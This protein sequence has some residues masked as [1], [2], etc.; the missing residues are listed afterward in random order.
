MNPLSSRAHA[1]ELARLLD[2]AAPAAVAG[3]A[4]AASLLGV[5]ERVRAF[6]A[7]LAPAVSPR[8]SWRWKMMSTI[9]IGTAAITVPAV[10]RLR[11]SGLE[12]DSERSPIWTVR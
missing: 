9:T 12:L 5:A 8:I 1:E 7:E 4:S 2:G 11:R 6:G 3:D 10:M